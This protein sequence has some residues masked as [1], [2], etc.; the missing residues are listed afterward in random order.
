MN[1][2]FGIVICL[3]AGSVPISL[4]SMQGERAEWST[5]SVAV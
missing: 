3:A 4:L 2:I 1:N 5:G